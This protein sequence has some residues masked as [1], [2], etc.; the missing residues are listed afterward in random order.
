[1]IQFIKRTVFPVVGL[2]A[3]LSAARVDASLTSISVATGAGEVSLITPQEGAAGSSALNQGGNV[4]KSATDLSIV[5]NSTTSTPMGLL[6]ELYGRGNYTRVSDQLDQLW[7][8]GM[9]GTSSITLELR[10]A[11]LQY[12]LGIDPYPQATASTLAKEF[13]PLATVIGI[14]FS[15]KFSS[16]DTSFAHALSADEIQIFRTGTTVQGK[17]Y[18]G[19]PDPFA[20]LLKT[21]VTGQ[22]QTS[23]VWSTLVSQ[24]SDGLDHVVTYKVGTGATTR[25]VLAFEDQRGG[26][27]FAYND[28]IFE[29]SSIPLH[30]PEPSSFV[31][32]GVSVLGLIGYHFSRRLTGRRRNP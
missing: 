17:T 8:H 22:H 23:D 29:V 21:T 31:I 2:L 25:Y 4:F 24:N 12:Q 14:G 1:M 15:A 30:A 19:L 9:N 5:K 7:S 10:Y 27:D 18:E 11:G 20:W 28:A 26:G 13:T 3:A 6:D 32:G 16:V